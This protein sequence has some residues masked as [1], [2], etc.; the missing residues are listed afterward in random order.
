MKIA[1]KFTNADK[2]IGGIKRFEK[3]FLSATRAAGKNANLL[4]KES[5]KDSMQSMWPPNAPDYLSWKRSNGYG[6]VPLFR[7][8]LLYNSISHE[9]K[10]G[11][12]TIKGQIGWHEGARYPGDL[13]RKTWKG[14]VPNR[15]KKDLGAPTGM[16]AEPTSNHDTN[17]LAQVAVWNE[18]GTEGKTKTKRIAFAIKNGFRKNKR[19]DAKQKFR[20][21]YYDVQTYEPSGRPPRPFVE[22][23]FVVASD[24]IY[25]SFTI[26]LD[27]TVS[28][29]FGRYGKAKRVSSPI[30]N[31]VPF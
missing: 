24:M 16:H 8:N 22:R 15:R 9:L 26:A 10:M 3:T 5:I 6:T 12:D 28:T 1:V 7:T 4:A 17:Y 20:N 13:K 19:G 27:K 25:N 29:M 14:R 31:D 30:R 2:I 11:Q 21:R 23:A 18:T